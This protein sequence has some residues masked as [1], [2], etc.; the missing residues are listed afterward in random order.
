MVEVGAKP[1]Q[2]RRAIASGKICLDKHTIE[3]IQN[4]EIKKGKGT[5]FDP[6]FADIML[7][8]MEEDKNY[9][10]REK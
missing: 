9:D 4:E 7:E 5:Q 8:I 2:K 6:V 10:L 1:D 3:L